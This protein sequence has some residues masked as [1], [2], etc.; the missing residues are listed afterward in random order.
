MPNRISESRAWGLIRGDLINPVLSQ[1]SPYGGGD[2]L[3]AISP[4]RLIRVLALGSRFL[5]SGR[6]GDKIRQIAFP[7]RAPGV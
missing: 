4:D 6:P 1:T 2:E 5:A 3:Y 7:S